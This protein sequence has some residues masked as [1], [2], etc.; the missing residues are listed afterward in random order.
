MKAGSGQRK[1]PKVV[2]A[3]IGSSGNVPTI[4]YSQQVNL[5]AG[6][7]SSASDFTS[8]NMNNSYNKHIGERIASALAPQTAGVFSDDRPCD[9]A[10][11]LGSM[12]NNL[13]R[14][15][16]C[17]RFGGWAKE[18]DQL[19]QMVLRHAWS[20]WLE[21]HRAGNYN[22]ELNK[23]VT[24]LA[25]LEWVSEDRSM[26]TDT[27]RAKLLQVGYRR[28]TDDLKEHY[29]DVLAWLDRETDNALGEYVK[30]LAKGYGV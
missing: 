17:A 11:V 20:R 3:T 1:V 15:L 8:G 16:L 5:S 13:H 2:Q 27:Y 21:R 23:N 7:G 26:L 18:Q 6:R 10:A 24:D 12:Q 28:Y 14:I 30:I 29:Q 4:P 19:K 9:V 22:A 25:L